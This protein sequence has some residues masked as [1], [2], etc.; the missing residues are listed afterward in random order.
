MFKLYERG[1]SSRGCNDAASLALKTSMAL[2][3]VLVLCAA[4]LLAPT[5]AHAAVGPIVQTDAGQVQGFFR[6]GVAEF[7]G[8]PYAAPPVSTDPTARPCSRTNLRWC[9]PVAHARWTGVLRAAAYAPICA[10]I[11]TLGVF[12]GPANANEDCLYLNVFTPNVRGNRKLP[13][14]FWI[15]GGGNIDGETRGYDGSKMALKGQTVVV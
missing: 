3:L 2:G 10:Q 8:I 6:N 4:I 11:E 9:P 12:A 5:Q 15:H 14:I 7:L 13:V 1:L